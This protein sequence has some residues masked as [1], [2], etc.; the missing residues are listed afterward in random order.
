[1]YTQTHT[2]THYHVCRN[3][4]SIADIRLKALPFRA[5]YFPACVAGFY[6]ELELCLLNILHR[7]SA[8]CCCSRSPRRFLFISLISFWALI[9][10]EKKFLEFGWRKNKSSMVNCV[11]VCMHTFRVTSLK[12]WLCFFCHLVVTELYGENFFLMDTLMRR[13]V[14]SGLSADQLCCGNSKQGG[15]DPFKKL[16]C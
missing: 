4:K 5:G 13:L 15:N 12:S 16:P 7:I 8:R 3:K 14:R 10:S 11:F 2:R 1:M 9:A 6:C